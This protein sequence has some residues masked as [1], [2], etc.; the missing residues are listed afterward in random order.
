MPSA[1]KDENIYRICQYD[2]T[3]LEGTAGRNHVIPTHS[4]KLPTEDKQKKLLVIWGA[5]IARPLKE[6]SEKAI[7]ALP[8]G[9]V[10]EIKTLR[11]IT[12]ER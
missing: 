10:A 9:K 7:V 12:R 8:D 4:A 2:G 3:Y 11:I 1:L 5:V 6:T